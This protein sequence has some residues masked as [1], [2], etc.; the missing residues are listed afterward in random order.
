MSSRSETFRQSLEGKLTA[1]SA[2]V[3][4]LEVLLEFDVLFIDFFFQFQNFANN[5]VAETGR[6]WCQD[7]AIG[8]WSRKRSFKFASLEDGALLPIGQDSEPWSWSRPGQ[9]KS[10]LTFPS[11]YVIILCFN[12]LNW[13]IKK[14]SFVSKHSLRTYVSCSIIVKETLRNGVTLIGRK[15]FV[16]CFYYKQEKKF[17]VSQ[18]LF[19]NNCFIA[20][21]C[22]S[23]RSL[24]WNSSLA[25]SFRLNFASK[26]LLPAL[27]G[28]R[29]SWKARF[30][31]A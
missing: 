31:A 13:E 10:K 25:A 9:W 28:Q 2:G 23:L 22:F 27:T 4:T 5:F 26:S 16:S 17:P 3:W 20:N 1:R 21:L 19:R 18:E 14:C 24:C 29:S 11:V 30:S 12:L 8:C 15:I 7:R 6:N